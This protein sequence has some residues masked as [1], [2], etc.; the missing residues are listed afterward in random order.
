MKTIRLQLRFLLP[1]VVILTAA[2]YLALPVMDRLTLRWFARD[3]DMRGTLVANALSESV[4]DD[5]QD[6]R[7]RRLQALFDRAVQDERL[8]AIAWCSTA[9]QVMRRTAS[10]PAGLSCAEAERVAAAKAPE[11]HIGGGSVH[12]SI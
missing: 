7:G 12:V 6:S 1:L 11:L 4:A 9:G 8:V 2:A 3:L 5:L 10:F